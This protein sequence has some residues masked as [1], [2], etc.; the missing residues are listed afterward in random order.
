MSVHLSGKLTK[1]LVES[2]PAG[3]HGDGNGLFLVVD[4]SGARRWVL[5]VTIKGQK[6]AKGGPLRP[7]F[8]L[9]GA[10]VT[11]LYDARDR[12]LKYRILAK[13]GINPKYSA[14]GAIP[15]FE[16]VA[17]Q[18][19]HDRLGCSRHAVSYWEC[20]TG[21]IYTRWGVPAR[22]LEALGVAA[23]P[24]KQTTTHGRGDG[25]LLDSQQARI[26]RRVAMQ[27]ERVLCRWP[28]GIASHA[29]QRHQ[30]AR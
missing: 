27:N 21:E 12:A 30:R 18:V 16:E 17:R 22:I 4:P 6:N 19:H 23:L 3:R 7:D 5:R 25:V 26:D 14:V 28:Q 20:K 9:D 29:G 11:S 8:G 15:S 10:N 24:I 2:L 13:Q 1:R